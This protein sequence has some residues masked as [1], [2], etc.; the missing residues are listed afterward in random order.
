[1][2][3]QYLVTG[4]TANSIQL[5]VS[6]C[7]YTTVVIYINARPEWH[8][9]KSS[10]AKQRFRKDFAKKKIQ[11]TPNDPHRRHVPVV[12]CSFFS[13]SLLLH[14]GTNQLDYGK[15]RSC[16]S[17]L[18]SGGVKNFSVSITRI[19]R[20][21]WWYPTFYAPLCTSIAVKAHISDQLMEM[22]SQY[23]PD[24]LRKGDHRGKDLQIWIGGEPMP[25]LRMLYR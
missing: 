22:Q 20:V 19:C 2:M 7:A 3:T 21:I 6:V 5:R 8:I 24:R 12:M 10:K 25:Y 11:S 1:M 23:L 17:Q 4:A 9:T 14:A 16:W 13:P 18:H 15:T